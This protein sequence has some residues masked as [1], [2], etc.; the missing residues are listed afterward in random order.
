MAFGDSFTLGEVT[1]P[2]AS[3]GLTKLVVVPTAAYPL[4]LQ[5]QLAGAYPTQSAVI[6]VANA[7]VAGE[8]LL[9]GRDRFPGALQQV[10]P[11]V[12]LLM[13][14]GNGLNIVGPDISTDLV[15]GMARTAQAAG[16]R[17]FVG[18]MLPQVSGRPRALVPSNDLVTY[19]TRLQA[20][21]RQDGHVFVDLYNAMLGEAGTLIG[22]DGLHPTEVGYKRIA[23]VFF[24]AIKTNLEVK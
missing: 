10:R 2:I 1:W 23:D 16:A 8:T 14:G 4:I 24:A 3:G 17:V 9:E 13:E 15:A 22:V 19:N 21:S 7:G 6:A 5:G 20:M 12:V 11:E 18:S